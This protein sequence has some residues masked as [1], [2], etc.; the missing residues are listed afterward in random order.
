M[1]S[2]RSALAGDGESASAAA[3]ELPA[4]TVHHVLRNG[5][6]RATLR[7]LAARDG[8]VAVGDLAE[9]VA[10]TEVGCAP[11]AVPADA[12][13][14][15]YVALHQTHLGTLADHG[16]VRHERGTV[17]AGPALAQFEP[18]L[19]EKR[20]FPWD[21]LARFGGLGWVAGSLATAAS[22]RYLSLPTVATLSVLMGVAAAV[23]AL[24]R[25]PRSVSAGRDE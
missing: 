20:R 9:H 6:R 13:R 4:S 2:S 1:G 11:A 10:A 18:F 21:E 23:A 24:R 12:R 15:V 3:T 14:R 19:L 8:P 7:H 25:R 22:L 16:V 17:T 5:R